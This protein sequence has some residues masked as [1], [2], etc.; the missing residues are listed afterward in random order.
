[1]PHIPIHRDNHC[2]RRCPALYAME[3]VIQTVRINRQ[4]EKMKRVF[5][6]LSPDQSQKVSDMIYNV[7]RS[8][9]RMGVSGFAYT[10]NL[11]YKYA[12]ELLDIEPKTGVHYEQ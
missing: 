10:M 11:A 5:S 3:N 8:S 7:A 6:M 12:C 2:G 4:G 9:F 1:M